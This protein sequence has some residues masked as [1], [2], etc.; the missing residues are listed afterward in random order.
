[1]EKIYFILTLAIMVSSLVTGFIVFRMQ[2]MSLAPHFGML[3]LA[4]VATLAAIFTNVPLVYYSAAVLQFI[5]VI[6]GYT[7]MF[8][9]LKYNFQT[10][11]AY[12]PHL[13]LISILP[14]LILAGIFL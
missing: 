7:Q 1:M 5:A 13:A 8:K 12:A 4:L 3:I 11:P 14:V 6:T 2:G 10:A 9:V